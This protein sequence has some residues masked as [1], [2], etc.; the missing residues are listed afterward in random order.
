M[1]LALMQDMPRQIERANFATE[2]S[3]FDVFK[4]LADSF[5]CIGMAANQHADQLSVLHHG[6]S[7]PFAIAFRILWLP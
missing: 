4:A 2:F 1:Q 7:L 5:L 3:I 6:R